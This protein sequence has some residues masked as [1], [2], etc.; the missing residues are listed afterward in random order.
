[1][2][3]R[4]RG[5]LLAT[6]LVPAMLSACT[7]ALRA[8]EVLAFV[9]PQGELIAEPSVIRPGEALLTFENRSEADVELALARLDPD[10]DR[11]PTVDG[12][13]PIGDAGDLTYRGTGYRILAKGDELR[14]FISGRQPARQVLHPHLK[15]GTHLVFETARGRYSSGAF[16]AIEVR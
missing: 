2:G 3:L 14:R 7:T 6:M 5:G 15:R 10:V 13:V 4:M 11:L 16:V 9:S 8:P 1:M 12:L